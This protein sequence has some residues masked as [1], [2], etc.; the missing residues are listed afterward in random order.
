[1]SPALEK[2]VSPHLALG[3]I[4]SASFSL[5]DTDIG[6]LIEDFENREVRTITTNHVSECLRN[7]TLEIFSKI[8]SAV[9]IS[10]YE[11]YDKMLQSPSARRLG[12]DDKMS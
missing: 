3:T 8:E 10:P 5:L 7:E 12:D 6:R 11:L 2:L 9:R 4:F 1:M